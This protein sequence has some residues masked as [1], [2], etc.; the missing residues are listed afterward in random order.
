MDTPGDF[1]N[2][3]VDLTAILASKVAERLATWSKNMDHNERQRIMDMVESNLPVVI[4][5]TISKTASL[6]SAAGVKYLE[7]HLEDW[8]DSWARKF[9]NY[10]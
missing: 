1:N 6:H 8:A 7:E 9:I 2:Q 3:L 4:A 5:N 10:D